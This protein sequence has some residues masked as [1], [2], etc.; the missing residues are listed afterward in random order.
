MTMKF[1][2]ISISICQQGG[3]GFLPRIIKIDRW[4]SILDSRD[5]RPSEYFWSNTENDRYHSQGW[6]LRRFS[7]LPQI[8][9]KDAEQKMK[10]VLEKENGLE[11]L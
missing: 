1:K 2:Q 6:A 10:D 7:R 8:T 4:Y 11:I 9:Q 5:V 3:I